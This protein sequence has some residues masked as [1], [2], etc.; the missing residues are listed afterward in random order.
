V[1]SRASTP[2]SRERG[3]R[4]PPQKGGDPYKLSA[5]PDRIVCASDSGL[6]PITKDLR[7]LRE[8]PNFALSRRQR[9]FES[10]W[11]HQVKPALTRPDT[12]ISQPASPWIDRQGRA[13]DAPTP[14]G[15]ALARPGSATL[16]AQTWARVPAELCCREVGPRLGPQGRLAPLQR[17]AS[18]IRRHYRPKGYPTRR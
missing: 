9:G 7:R 3:G 16:L 1:W 5:I 10:R 13:R 12:T 8:M 15:A 2:R 4:T 17:R 18:T 6:Q 14:A 11:G